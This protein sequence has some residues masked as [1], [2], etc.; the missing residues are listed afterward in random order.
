M[1]RF[2]LTRRWV[3]LAAVVLILVPAFL[4]LSRW[5]WH[6]HL[7]RAAF[8]SAVMDSQRAPTVPL[9]SLLS[10]RVQPSDAAAL[11]KSME[12]R[13]VTV[14]GRYLP[15]ERPYVRRRTL[16]MADGFWVLAELKLDSGAILVVN[17]GWTPARGGPSASP[18]IAPPPAG[19][20]SLTGHLRSPELARG[21]IPADTPH[22]QTLSVD[23]AALTPSGTPGF[24]SYLELAVSQPTDLGGLSPIPLPA[25]DAGPH[26]AY[27]VEWVLFAL[28]AIGGFV[29]L[30]MKEAKLPES[31]KQS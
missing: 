4:L 19:E 20:V 8:N 29:L 11:P 2:L 5:Q 23:V 25:L 3:G 21:T 17:R 10:A 31:P 12:W 15:V 7:Q 13:N 22:D 6:R 27:A 14:S 1:Y 18:Q 16:N 28:L 9:L 26:L 30:A 24:P